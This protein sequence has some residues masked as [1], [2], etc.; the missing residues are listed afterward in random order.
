MSIPFSGSRSRS[1]G[2]IS[3]IAKQLKEINLKLVNRII[4]QFD[5]FH[6]N[7]TETRKFLF[8]ISAPRILKTNPFCIL[9]TK[10]VCDRTEPIVTFDLVSNNKV[11][12]KCKNL[13]ALDI[14]QYCNKHISSLVPP[15]EKS[16]K[17]LLLEEKEK[18]RK[19]KRIKQKPF[20]KRRH[21]IL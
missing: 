16:P 10:I 7:V 6:E 18:K 3:A 1:G 21:V 9:K 11:I 12:F 20:T 19:K 5:P 8:Y 17:Q 14:L 13:T 2:V 4:V 15:P